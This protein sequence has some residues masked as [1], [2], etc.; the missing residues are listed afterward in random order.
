MTQLRWLKVFGICVLV[1]SLSVSFARAVDLHPETKQRLI[2][3]GRWEQYKQTVLTARAA[4]MNQPRPRP[5]LAKL[6]ASA[7]T[8]FGSRIPCIL[9]EFSDNLW[10]DGATNT[11]PGLVDSMLFSEGEYATG[12]FREYYLENSYGAFAATG[13][14]VVDLL[15]KPL[16]MPQTYLYYVGANRGIGS[17]DSNSQ[18]LARDA[19][20]AADPFIDFSQYDT[21]GDLEVDGVMIIFAGFGF[22]EAA[23]EESQT[24]QS[25]QWVMLPGL[26]L[27]GVSIKEYTVQPEEHGRASGIDGTNGIGVWCHEWSHILNLPDLYD[28]DFSSWGIGR[29]SIM[30]NGNYLNK[31][32]TP[33]H[34]DPWCKMQLGWV[35]VVNLQENRVDQAIPTYA[36]SPT[37]YRLWMPGLTGQEYF[38]VCN[39]HQTGFDAALPGSG[40]LILH[41]DDNKH[42]NMSEYIPGPG[43]LPTS[44]YMVAVVQADGNYDLE[45][46][47]GGNPGDAGDLY[48]DKTVEFDDLTTPSS[49]GYS[50]I[51]TQV[52]V[53]NISPTGPT[54][55]ANLDV[56]YS[57][58]L[59]IY[60]NHYF[61]DSGGDDDGA[62]DPGETVEMY[63]YSTNLWKTTTEVYL[64]VSCSNPQVIFNNDTSY[65]D[66]IN[67]GDIHL[68]YDDPI[69]FSIPATLQPTIADFYINYSAEGGAFTFAETLSV[70]LGPK[71]VLIVDDDAKYLDTDYDHYYTDA[72]ETL[73]IPYEVHHKDTQG[74]P[75]AAILGSYP[76]V[77]WY[78]GYTDAGRSDPLLAYADVVA[79][80]EYLDD[81][82]RLFLTGQNIAQNMD[83][84]ST[85]IIDYLGVRYAPGMPM[86]MANGVADDPISDGHVLPLGGPGGAANQNS[87]DILELTD[88]LA[89]PAYTYYGSSD[90]AGVHV[91]AGHY[92]AVFLG[93]GVEAIADG[94]PGYTKRRELISSVIYWLI[95]LSTGILEEDET[96]FGE[97]AEQAV[98]TKYTL[99]QNYPNPFNGRTIIEYSV[100]PGQSGDISIDI[101][102]I[103]GRRVT[104][105]FRG[106][107]IPGIHRVEW[108]GRD[109]SGRNVS[110]G[111]Y[112]YRIL[113]RDGTGQSRRMVYLK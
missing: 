30:G 74:S 79:L 8:A 112:F 16:M 13:E 6:A 25:H 66:E 24:M 56:T 32:N 61:E 54:M 20:L 41:C 62:P 86:I 29:W 55:T 14:V 93:F 46:Y 100:A 44:H 10:A 60:V 37:V 28:L 78:T 5:K 67:S 59:I 98:P 71:Q 73:R 104:T 81:G 103:L 39:R 101:I 2:E 38:L 27:D 23:D 83:D 109:N 57:R 85:F 68:N 110:S 34:F 65:I 77:C 108:D 80:Q 84:D 19:I 88:G 63:I 12:S 35:S 113:D 45:R 95:G 70:D 1:L 51:K 72:L 43:S 31:S 97:F 111:V 89:V 53:W 64:T 3:S 40:L 48:T 47:E 50:G 76:M 11:S 42:S 105:I 58:P 106:I 75:S 21:D 87:P 52:A 26:N 22:E 7:T 107:A 102:D 69:S 90:I 18:T 94:L 92:R 33:S 49:R 82:G 9:V 4:G 36:D 91:D 15:G 96:E 17:P 99:F